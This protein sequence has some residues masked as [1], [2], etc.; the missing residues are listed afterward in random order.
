[1]ERIVL[2]CSDPGDL[3]ADPF[4]GSGTT[5]VAARKHGRNFWGCELSRTYLNNARARILGLA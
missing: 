5:G 3:V 4:L 2:A 1:M